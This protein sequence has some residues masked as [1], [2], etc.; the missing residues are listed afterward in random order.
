VHEFLASHPEFV[1]D[2]AIPDKLLITVAPDG[3]LKRCDFSV[4]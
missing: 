2:K 1:I 3:Y 4:T